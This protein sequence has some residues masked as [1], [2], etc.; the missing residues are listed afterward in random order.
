MNG[1]CPDKS[2]KACVLF[3]VHLW[4]DKDG[5]EV[6]LSELSLYGTFCFKIY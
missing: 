1:N 2:V 6:E 3:M 4:L 5:N